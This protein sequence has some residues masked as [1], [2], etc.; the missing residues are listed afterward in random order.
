LER[1]EA[2]ALLRQI[3]DKRLCAFS[4]VSIE[5][6][7][8]GGFTLLIKGDCISKEIKELTAE[9]NLAVKEESGSLIIYKP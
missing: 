6:S 3:V 4:L 8:N 7:K 9:R 1:K 2:V 5:K